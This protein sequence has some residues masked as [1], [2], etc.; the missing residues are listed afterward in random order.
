MLILEACAN[1]QTNRPPR[2]HMVGRPHPHELSVTM[3]VN[4]YFLQ[5]WP[6]PDE[7]SRL[8]FVAEGLP[9]WHCCQY[10]TSLNDRVVVAS[11]FTVMLFLVDDL[12]EHMSLQDGSS[13][14]ERLISIVK[15]ETLPA[16]DSPIEKIVLEIWQ[17]MRAIDKP[18]S[19][20][21]EVPTFEFWR[22][23][24]AEARLA[25]K[26]I[27]E[28]LEYRELDVASQLLLALQR[29][30]QGITVTKEELASV[31]EI[32][33]NYTH[34]ISVINDI[35]SWDKEYRASKDINAEGSIVSNIVQVLANETGLDYDGSKRV[36][37]T[38]CREWER[39]HAD[40]VAKRL[41]EGCSDSLKEY[42]EGIE[43]QMCGNELWSR[44]TFRYNAPGLN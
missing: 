7:R 9:T 33:L 20:D 3:L 19:D 41:E 34:H 25:K 32:E 22:S 35:L 15:G 44:T 21:V 12:L 30:S 23:Q 17:Q 1:D 11:R 26:S 18:L 40:L 8:K 24:N 27:A 6:F 36:L 31:S 39:N 43:L 38:M 14:N 16:E 28:Y 13:Y 10:P 29:F 2:S 4:N 37:W 5:N 42:L